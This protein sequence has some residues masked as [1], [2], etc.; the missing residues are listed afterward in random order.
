[1]LDLFSSFFAITL[2]HHPVLMFHSQMNL[3]FPF[4][5][6]SPTRV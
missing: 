1:M 5:E 3:Y 2:G 6:A 4:A